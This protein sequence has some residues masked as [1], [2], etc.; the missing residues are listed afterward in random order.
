MIR[1]RTYT[2]IVFDYCESVA[3]GEEIA[4]RFVKQSIAKFLDE[5]ER[6]DRHDEDFPF[7]FDRNA[8]ENFCG[9][10]PQFLRHYK[11]EWAGQPFELLPWQ[12]F[13][14]ANIH[15]WKQ[16]SDGLRRFR[17]ALL[18]VARKNG[19]TALCAGEELI[20]L[21]LDNEPGAEVYIGATKLDQAKLIHGDAESMV[22][23]SPYLTKVTDVR[24]NRL[25][26]PR[27]NG[28]ALPLGSDKPFSGLNPSAILFDEFHEWT[29]KHEPFYST[30]TTASGSRR[31]PLQLSISTA[32]NDA[33]YLYNDEVEYARSVVD[34]EFVDNQFF[35]MIYELDEED[36]P[37]GDDFDFEL[38]RKSNPSFGVS[39]KVEY[40]ESQLNEARNR[41]ILKRLDFRRYHGNTTVGA[42]GASY[43]E[44]NVG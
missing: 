22:L 20:F 23:Q 43:Y 11:G 16:R 26:F 38:L 30:M 15:G 25:I 17:R 42:L 33:S 41:S 37:F 13:F 5:V 8:V 3:S 14:I 7:E 31:Q 10:F 18:S 28:K 4:C 1:N 19:K 36:D 34:G 6:A 2:D 9:A 12:V 35:A 32:G 21:Y 29:A 40:L 27:L 24:K 44:E 39:A